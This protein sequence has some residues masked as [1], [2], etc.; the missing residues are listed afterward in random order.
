MDIG[1]LLRAAQD[2]QESNPRFSLQAAIAALHWTAAGR[3]Y[4][5]RSGDV[6]DARRFALEAAE[7]TGQSETVQALLDELRV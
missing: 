4:E 1:T 2:F 5:L 6:W 3:F 7:A